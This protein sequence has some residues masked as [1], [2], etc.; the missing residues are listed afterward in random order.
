MIEE[1]AVITWLNLQSKEKLG[2][3]GQTCDLRCET[4]V[5]HFSGNLYRMI[6]SEQAWQTT[7]SGASDTAT[8]TSHKVSSSF[9]PYLQPWICKIPT[10]IL[11]GCSD[12][13]QISGTA[14]AS[15]SSLSCFSVPSC[16]NV[17]VCPYWFDSSVCGCNMMTCRDASDEVQ[18]SIHKSAAKNCDRKTD[19]EQQFSG[20]KHLEKGRIARKLRT[21]QTPKPFQSQTTPCGINPGHT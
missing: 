4:S 7:S 20:S 1:G 14:A 18:M 19:S 5:N 8:K 21:A 12:D 16:R 15:T 9:V 10:S 17:I 3:P 11:S 13:V 6:R 2:V